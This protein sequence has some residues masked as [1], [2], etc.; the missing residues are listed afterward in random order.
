MVELSVLLSG[1]RCGN[2]KRLYESIEKSYSGSWEFIIVSPYKLPRSLEGKTNIK[3]IEDWGAP[4]R[5]YQRALCES[6]GKYITWAADDGVYLPNALD[7]G[8]QS[9]RDKEN[10]VIVGNYN[11]GKDNPDMLDIKYYYIYTHEGSRCEYLP[12][13]CLM[14]MVGI[15]PA[16]MMKE[17][18][19]W[20]CRWEACP[21]GFN[22]L[23]IRLYNKGVK[24]IFQPQQMFKCG[25]MPGEAGD[26]GP[27][28]WAQTTRDTPIFKMIY[29]DP[30]SRGRISIPLDNWKSSPERWVRRF[31]R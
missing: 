11:E 15:V 17:I 20:D 14:L 9:I 7:L 31:G 25:H 13:D 24:F 4:M 12:K 26:H 29:S 1:I 19:G 28:H 6:T 27:I 8:M 18:G 21:M 16:D 2:W 10:T 3:L 30:A 22:D 5:C 23:S